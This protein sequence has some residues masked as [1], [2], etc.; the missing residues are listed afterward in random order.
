MGDEWSAVTEQIQ[1]DLSG[2]GPGRESSADPDLC[3]SALQAVDSLLSA[4]DMTEVSRG[5]LAGR[6]IKLAAHPSPS[7]Q[8]A[9]VAA[10]ASLLL[11]R[12][13]D[14]APLPLDS[15]VP[16]AALLVL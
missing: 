3:V 6:M 13:F 2:P 5:H 12:P 10:M 7:V 11:S 8:L 9:T 15:Q 14:H 4:W 1:R 16:D